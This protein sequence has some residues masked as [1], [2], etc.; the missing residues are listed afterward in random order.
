MKIIRGK[1]AICELCKEY[2]ELRPYGFEGEYIC[3][4][5]GMKQEKITALKFQEIL[6]DN[7]LVIIDARGKTETA[8]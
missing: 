6:N 4:A 3:F 8:H 1:N 5:C 2:A 7:T